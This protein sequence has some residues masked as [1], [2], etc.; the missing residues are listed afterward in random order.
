[1]WQEKFTDK[2]LVMCGC[3][4][5]PDLGLGASTFKQLGH[6][7]S[8]I[9]HL[10]ARVN[11]TQPY[12]RHRPANTI[13]TL[14]IIELALL[15]R[16]KSVQYVSSIS[17]FGPTGY[18]TGTRFVSE[19]DSLMKHL[20]ALPY[21]HGYA[22]SQWVVEEM[23]HRLMT[24]G[25]PIAVYRP[26]FITGHSKTGACNPDDF[27]SRLIQ[28][29]L[30]MGTYPLLPNQRKEFIPVDYVCDVILHIASSATTVGIAY[31]IVPPN[32]SVSIDMNKSMDLV[33]QASG[34][35]LRGVTYDEWL[36]QLASDPK[37]SLQPLQ[38]M[39]AEKVH[40]GLTRWELYENMPV[41]GTE[42]AQAA[43]ADYPGG[44]AFPNLDAGLMQRYLAWL[45]GC[46]SHASSRKFP[47]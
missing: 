11:Y 27:F 28:A 21:D 23:L 25:F 9:F 38:P 2:L 17:C 30:Q 32:M 1:V 20:D 39:L 7:A 13:G 42:N 36:K 46:W 43:L 33:G 5:E 31:H 47:F 4:E 22:Q 16:P 40:N 6:W 26:G 45:Q 14:N 44:L 34:S 41:Y 19:G 15:G 18:F 8:V 3:L 29:C 35:P 37:F 24:R 12:S 10:G